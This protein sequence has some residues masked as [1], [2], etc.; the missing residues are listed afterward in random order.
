MAKVALSYLRMI[1]VLPGEVQMKGILR[2][3]PLGGDVRIV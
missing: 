2:G 1:S 3:T